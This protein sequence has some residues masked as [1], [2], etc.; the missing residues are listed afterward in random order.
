MFDELI[1]VEETPVATENSTETDVA[2]VS[3]TSGEPDTQSEQLDNTILNYLISNDEEV[4]SYEDYMELN[5]FTEE[6]GGFTH[7]L[8]S[9][10]PFGVGLGTIFF[11]I[12]FGI[13]KAVH[14]AFNI[15]NNKEE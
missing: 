10:I 3:E 5:F 2:P 15:N 1:V 7:A 11:L 4:L 9:F 8:S 13:S 12:G 6:E 14:I